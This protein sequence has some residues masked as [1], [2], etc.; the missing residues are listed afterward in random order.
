MHGQLGCQGG[1]RTGSTGAIKAMGAGLRAMRQDEV[2]Q[3]T[4]L[5]EDSRSAR[6]TG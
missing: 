3:Y 2:T 5:L 4:E 1:L 6:S